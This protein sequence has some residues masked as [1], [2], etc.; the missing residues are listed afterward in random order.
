M[1]R[2]ENTEKGKGWATRRTKDNAVRFDA[3]GPRE[4]TEPNQTHL[5]RRL[6]RDLAIYVCIGIV[7]VTSAVGIAVYQARHNLEPGLPLKWLG[8]GGATAVVFGYSVRSFRRFWK[9]VY[10]WTVLGATF[11]IHVAIGILAVSRS[12]TVPLVY[13]A[14][15]PPIELPLI[16][17]SVKKLVASLDRD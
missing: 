11:V 6:V 1:L 12:P 13:F 8:F 4:R 2:T 14:F 3:G 16:H 15:L 10:F 9:S 17:A 7:V 5:K